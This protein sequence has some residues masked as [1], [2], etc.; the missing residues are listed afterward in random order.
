MTEQN[1]EYLHSDFIDDKP[2]KNWKMPMSVKLARMGFT[3]GGRLFPEFAAKIAYHQFTKPRIRAKHKVSDVILERA[4]IFEFLYGKRLLKGYEWGE[5]EQT[6]LLVHGWESRGTALRNFVPSLLGKGYKI[7]TF[8]GPAHGDSGGYRTNMIHFAGAVKAILNRI[9]SIR[10][11]ITHSFG[12]AST[13]FALANW[14]DAPFVEKLVQVAVPNSIEKIFNDAIELMNLPPLAS[15]KFKT[16][17]EEKAQQP[18]HSMNLTDAYD[19]IQ[20]GRSL[21]IHDEEDKVVPIQSAKEI[22][23]VWENSTLVIT[24]G[25][26]H[27]RL[28]KNPDVI[29][30]VVEFIESK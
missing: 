5:G 1:I 13:V 22:S 2:E 6:I 15:K 12:G 10:G 7:V 28:L 27:F 14:S 19:L 4:R 21:L 3:I 9:P 26:G 30:R 29:K 25:Y 16:I 17:L 24:K 23:K 20:V 18:L 8:D 11:I